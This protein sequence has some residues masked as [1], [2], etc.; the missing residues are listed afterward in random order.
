MYSQTILAPL[1]PIKPTLIIKAPKPNLYQRFVNSH[2][3]SIYCETG[4]S[5]KQKHVD[6]ANKVW[7]E[8]KQQFTPS[9]VVIVVEALIAVNNEQQPRYKVCNLHPNNNNNNNNNNKTSI[10]HL[11]HRPSLLLPSS[12]PSS[13]TT[14][15]SSSPSSTPSSA[16]MSP[17]SPFKVPSP[18]PSS[19][20]SRSSPHQELSTPAIDKANQTLKRKQVE[21][22]LLES[23]ATKEAS[24]EERVEKRRKLEQ[25]EKETKEIEQKIAKM[26]NRNKI[27]RKYRL[28][29]RGTPTKHAEGWRFTP[30]DDHVY[31]LI[32]PSPPSSSYL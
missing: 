7:K 19:P 21:V 23:F 31:V 9:Q 5:N 11:R 10:N 22:A 8:L 25:L 27:Q 28:K 20:S 26:V 1:P 2:S 17:P 4:N 6:S 16:P 29:K 24:T 12:S 13:S 18:S 32:L 3:H 30:R 15:T 14:S